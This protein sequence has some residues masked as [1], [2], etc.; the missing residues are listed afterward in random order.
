MRVD[1]AINFQRTTHTLEKFSPY[2]TIVETCLRV[3]VVIA[4]NLMQSITCIPLFAA[5][6]LTVIRQPSYASG[7]GR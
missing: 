2:N 1:V 4:E 6:T 5:K 3:I 7:Q